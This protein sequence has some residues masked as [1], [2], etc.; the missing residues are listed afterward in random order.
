MKNE[1]L[2]LNIYA[3]IFVLFAMPAFFIPE[4]FAAILQYSIDLPGAK[5]EFIAAYGGLILGVGI[6]LMICVREHTRL[7]LI[8]ILSVIGSLFIGRVIGFLLDHGTSGVQNTFLFIEFLTILLML[9]LLRSPK[10]K[11]QLCCN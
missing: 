10:L 9:K 6:F 11:K 7:G 1:T 4:A 3:F 5:M 8:A 2:I